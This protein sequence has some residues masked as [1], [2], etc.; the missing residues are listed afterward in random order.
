MNEGRKES[1]RKHHSEKAPDDVKVMRGNME[2]KVKGL[3][4]V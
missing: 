4:C 3:M 2:D 1:P